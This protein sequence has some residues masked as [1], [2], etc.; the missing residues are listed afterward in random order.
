MWHCQAARSAGPRSHGD[1]QAK[2]RFSFLVSRFS[3]GCLTTRETTN[4]KRET[5]N[6]LYGTRTTSDHPACAS[7]FRAASGISRVPRRRLALRGDQRNL[8]TF[9]QCV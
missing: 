6:V 2:D 8:H 1:P 9:T 4:E 7:A 5:R 3:F